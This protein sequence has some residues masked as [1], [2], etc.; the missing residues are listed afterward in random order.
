M[1]LG[2][3]ALSVTSL[4]HCVMPSNVRM[5]IAEAPALRPAAH[6]FFKFRASFSV[7]RWLPTY[8]AQD[9]RWFFVHS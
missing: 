7:A 8:I 6:H 2:T 9:F 4:S 5:D 1:P 3:G